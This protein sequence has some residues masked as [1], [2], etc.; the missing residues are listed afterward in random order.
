VNDF[1]VN[2]PTIKQ[3]QCFIAVAHELNFRRAAEQM[4]MSQPPLTRQ[5]QTLE[6]LLG[7]PLFTR[8]THQVQ[9]TEAGKQL[10][11]QAK[12]LIEQ[13]SRLVKEL[14]VESEKL[15]VG[16]TRALDFTLIPSIHAH[17]ATLMDIDEVHSYHLNSRQL[18]KMLDSQNLDI[19]F[20]GE[21]SSGHDDEFDFFWL[22]REPLM[23][24][25]PTS[26]PAALQDRVSLKDVA[27][28]A[29]FWFSRSANPSFYDKCEQ[30]FNALPFVLQFKPES[31]DSLLTLANVARGNGMALMPES[32]CLSTREGLCY[33]KLDEQTASHLNIDVYLATRKNEQRE[34]VLEA[35][36]TFLPVENL[37]DNQ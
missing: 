28:L 8:N 25:L 30:V 29:L 19:V 37:R 11:R 31:E 10:Q 6:A 17:L 33:R 14:K 1:S 4:K 24:A 2:L 13:L 32:M 7:Q 26:H 21:K 27:D 18:L 16:V 22:H 35:V 3:L 20:T 23:L 12:P 34:H 5:I 15:R 9:L 36:R